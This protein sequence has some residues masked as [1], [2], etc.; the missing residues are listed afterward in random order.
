MHI[1]SD[2]TEEFYNVFTRAREKYIRR[3]AQLTY[4]LIASIP[5]E[6]DIPTKKN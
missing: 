2:Y 3:Q 4:D 6:K 1:H 5:F